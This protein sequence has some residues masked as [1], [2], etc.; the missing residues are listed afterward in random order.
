MKNVTLFREARVNIVMSKS[1][2]LEVPEGMPEEE[3]LA[4]AEKEIV[5]PHNAV[6]TLID[7]L[8]RYGVMVSKREVADWEVEDI[9]FSS[10]EPVDGK[11]LKALEGE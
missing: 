11:D 6:N 10:G 5:L 9:K 3:F 8:S 7:I 4:K 2:Y 1:I